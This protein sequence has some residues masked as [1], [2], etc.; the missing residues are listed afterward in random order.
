M[1]PLFD[2]LKEFG[3]E[4]FGEASSIVQDTGDLIERVKRRAYELTH[5]DGDLAQFD[6]PE[7]LDVTEQPPLLVKTVEFF[8]VVKD[9]PAEVEKP[10]PVIEIPEFIPKP[11]S[12]EVAQRVRHPSFGVGTVF[13]VK[14]IG[15]VKF[16]DVNFDAAGLKT[17][18][19][20]MGKL[21]II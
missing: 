7:D 5:L 15:D 3:I 2:K 14:K 17:I 6:M 19:P 10:L 12:F 21:E 20:V 8:E 11:K 4:P 1:K 13:A 18:N 9:L 16:L